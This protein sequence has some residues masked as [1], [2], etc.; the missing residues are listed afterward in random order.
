[1]GFEVECAFRKLQMGKRYVHKTNHGLADAKDGVSDVEMHGYKIVT[2][3]FDG[4]LRVYDL[5]MGKL[6]TDTVGVESGTDNTASTN[7]SSPRANSNT[8]LTSISISQDGDTALISSLDSTIRLMDLESGLSL[9]TYHG[10]SNK[11]FRLKSLFYS[12]DEHLASPSEDGYLYLWNLMDEKFKHRI[13]VGPSNVPIAYD[14][15]TV[16]EQVKIVAGS[17]QSVQLF[18]LN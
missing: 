15:A 13:Q 3:S 7:N 10:H 1:M 11:T 4:K 17:F 6:I 9:Q 12:N 18:N 16:D 8:P 2:V 5:R 14:V